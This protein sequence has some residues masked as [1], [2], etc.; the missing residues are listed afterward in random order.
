MFLDLETATDYRRGLFNAIV[1]PRPIGWIST[2]DRAGRANLAPFSHFNLVSTAPPVLIFSC[3][4]AADRP[5]KDTVANVRATGEFV[6]NL[7]TWDLREAMNKTSLNLPPGVDEFEFA[8]LEKLPS[9]KVAPPRVAASPA[10]LECRLLRI[11][12]IEPT[13]S[14]ET[15]SSVVFGSIVAVHLDDEYVDAQGRFDV[16]RALPLTRLG[17]AQ[18]ATVGELVEMPRPSPPHP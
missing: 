15:H 14:G 12:E 4:A 16:A 9:M 18:Y 7:A 5:E 3:N 6:A 10:H 11:V 2:L 17:G 8:G 1:A 13:R